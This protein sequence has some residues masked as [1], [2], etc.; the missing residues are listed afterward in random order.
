[1]LFLSVE[2]YFSKRL[3][4]P[5]QYFCYFWDRNPLDVNLLSELGGGVNYA[6]KRIFSWGVSALGVMSRRSTDPLAVVIM[7]GKIL[8]SNKV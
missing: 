3:E 2:G 6:Q 7:R 4:F 8:A 5:A 1:M